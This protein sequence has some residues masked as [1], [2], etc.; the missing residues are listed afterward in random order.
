MIQTSRR[1]ILAAP[2]ALML[3]AAGPLPAGLDGHAV[4]KGL[5]YGA[6]I[7]DAALRS[8]PALTARIR[9]E[10]GIVV[11]EASFKWESLQPQQ[12]KFSFARADALLAFADKARLKARGHTLVWHEANPAWLQNALTPQT[13]EALLAGYIA[14]VCGHFRQKLVHWDVVNEPLHPEDGQPFGLRDT[15]WLRALGPRYIDIAFHAA[16]EADPG[17]LRVLNEFGVDYA[18]PWQEKRR[19]A[20]LALLSNLLT[21]GVPV[22]AVGLQAHLDA[23]ETALD[24]KILSRF[25]AD[26]AAMGL[27]VIVTEL[28]VRDDSLPADIPARDAAVAEHARAWLD[29]VL[30]NPAVLGV[31]TW[32]LSD[33][34]SWLNDKFPRPDGLPQRPLPLDSNLNR[35]PL[36][37][38]IAAALDAAAAR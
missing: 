20:M 15:P 13:G 29:A 10:C 38:A 27:K 36:W 5:F 18:I 4:A 8:D 25:V 7:D 31:V 33:R 32:G 30:P 21:R 16:A 37:G 9:A 28:D 11:S 3:G 6:A 19:A 26:I 34:R 1:S 14:T 23:S 12:N 24:Q 22:Q 2:A 17:A 35:T